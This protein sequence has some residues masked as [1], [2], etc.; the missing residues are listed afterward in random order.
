MRKLDIKANSNNARRGKRRGKLVVLGVL[1]L[2]ALFLILC[3]GYGIKSFFDK[4]R[5]QSPVVFR[6][7]IVKREH[8][9]NTQAKPSKPRSKP[10]QTKKRI[11]PQ[12]EASEVV[13]TEKEHTES[14]ALTAIKNHFGDEW[15]MAVAIATPESGMDCSKRSYQMNT[16]GTY[17][18]GLF[19]INEIHLYKLQEGESIYD[20]DVNAR[21]AKEIKDSWQGWHAWSV[22]NNG[23]YEQYL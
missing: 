19:Q 17:D 1:L 9:K 18:H 21:I 4:Y 14:D 8:N 16:N 15:K 22:Y 12:V 6:P 10:A 20:C 3:A 7:V 23:S 11:V 2:L 13:D 5:L